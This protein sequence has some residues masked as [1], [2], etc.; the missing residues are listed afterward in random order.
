MTCERWLL[1]PCIFILRKHLADLFN[2][3]SVDQSVKLCPLGFLDCC[4]EYILSEE[5]KTFHA[6][7]LVF[8]CGV[9]G[10]VFRHLRAHVADNGL[11]V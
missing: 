3:Q 11:N 10:I 4:W 5:R 1:F 9:V 7:P 2:R 8:R 6:A